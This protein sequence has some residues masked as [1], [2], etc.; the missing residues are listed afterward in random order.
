MI[1]Q[2]DEWLMDRHSDLLEASPTCCLPKSL[3]SSDE[4]SFSGRS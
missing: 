1:H 2:K 3:T 4:A